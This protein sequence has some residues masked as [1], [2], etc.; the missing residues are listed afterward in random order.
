MPTHHRNL[1]TPSRLVPGPWA[2]DAY[3]RTAGWSMRGVPGPCG[4]IAG[5]PSDDP[6]PD[7][8]RLRPFPATAISTLA[9]RVVPSAA[10]SFSEAMSSRSKRRAEPEPESLRRSS[11]KKV[12]HDEEEDFDVSEASDDDIDKGAYSHGLQANQRGRSSTVSWFRR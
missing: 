9:R 1:P 11:R 5:R 10:K 8:S 2:V 12:K 6:P 7:A 3:V 4:A